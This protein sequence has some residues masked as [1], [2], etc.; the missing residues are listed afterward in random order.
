MLARF[1]GACRTGCKA[2]RTE[3]GDESPDLPFRILPAG[4]WTTVHFPAASRAAAVRATAMRRLVGLR[5]G[6][7]CLHLLDRLGHG[8]HPLGTF[9]MQIL[10]QLAVDDDN[11]FAAC[12]CR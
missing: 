1:C 5:G 3:S 8:D 12:A 9:H 11:A 7:L 4:Q 6:N 10:D 2:V